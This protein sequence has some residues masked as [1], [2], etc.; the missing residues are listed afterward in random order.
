M[1]NDLPGTSYGLPSACN[2]LFNALPGSSLLLR[3]DAPRYTIMPATSRYLADTSTTKEQL[4]GRGIFEAFPNNPHDSEVTGE[5]DLGR[6]LDAVL[7]QKKPHY[8]PVQRYDVK[9]AAGSYEEKYWRASNDPVFNEE[10][11][12]LYIIHTVVDITDGI[13]AGLMEE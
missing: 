8:L 2:A 1:I 7:L 5:K 11:D 13:K 6:S 9:T 3:T 4:I 12:V 10:G